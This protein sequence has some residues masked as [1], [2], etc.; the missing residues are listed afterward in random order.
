MSF[1]MASWTSE[2]G[3]PRVKVCAREC[4]FGLR[5]SRVITGKLC[6]GMSSAGLCPFCASILSRHR[7][8]LYHDVLRVPPL[9]RRDSTESQVGVSWLLRPG[10]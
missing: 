8:V 5:P 4:G 3:V 10:L 9:L 7:G 2:N 6:P 1:V